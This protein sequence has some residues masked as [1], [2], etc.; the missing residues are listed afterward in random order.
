MIEVLVASLVFAQTGPEPEYDCWDIEPEH[1]CDVWFRENGIPYLSCG[2]TSCFP[3]VNVNEF[4]AMRVPVAAGWSSA[5]T[6]QADE[7]HKTC[8]FTAPI[9]CGGPNN[10]TCVYALFTTNVTYLDWFTSGQADCPA[11][12]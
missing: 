5:C 1:A 3:Q 11:M 2:S 7:P 4:V 6:S 8:D 10:A 12:E 9:S